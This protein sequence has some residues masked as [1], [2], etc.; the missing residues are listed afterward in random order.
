MNDSTGMKSHKIN[1]MLT[2]NTIGQHGGGVTESQNY[3]NNASA[4]VVTGQDGAT[5][6]IQQPRLT[7]E[8]AKENGMTPSDN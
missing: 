6:S 1:P 8:I 2:M 3:A 5:K 4:S 7:V